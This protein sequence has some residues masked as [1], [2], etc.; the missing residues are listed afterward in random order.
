[1]K[2]DKQYYQKLFRRY[3]DLVTVLQFREMLGGI[4]DCFARRIIQE[5]RVESFYIKPHY[6][7]PKCSVIDYVLSED[8]AERNL[9]VRV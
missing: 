5:Q 1:M 3:P 8:Y 2:K 4:G 7:V 9:K 6:F